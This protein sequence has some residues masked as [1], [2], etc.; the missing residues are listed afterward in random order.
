MADTFSQ[1]QQNRNDADYNLLKEWQPGQVALLIEAIEDA[2]KSWYV[3]R[4]DQAA[5]DFLISM[6]PTRE[7]KQADR[8]ARQKQK[9]RP[10][11]ADPPNPEIKRQRRRLSRSR[12]HDGWLLRLPFLSIEELLDVRFN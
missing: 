12:K 9:P 11:L 6:L 7:K 1:A 4:E 10:T 5:K 2:V 3:I 8:G